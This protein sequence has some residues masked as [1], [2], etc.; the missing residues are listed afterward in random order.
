MSFPDFHQR[1]CDTR[2]RFSDCSF[3]LIRSSSNSSSF[4]SSLLPTF[5]S[6]CFVAPFFRHRFWVHPRLDVRVRCSALRIRTHSSQ[7][8]SHAE[9]RVVTFHSLDSFQENPTS[10]WLSPTPSR[11]LLCSHPISPSLLLTS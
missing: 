6:F 5:V 2:C 3:K 9:A 11:Y 4:S 1:S 7:G 8:L 10:L